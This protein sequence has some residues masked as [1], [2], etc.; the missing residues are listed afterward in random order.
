MTLAPADNGRIQAAIFFCERTMTYAN[1]SSYEIDPAD[2]VIHVLDGMAPLEKA[3]I[4]AELMAKVAALSAITNAIQRAKASAEV[5]ALLRRIQGDSEPVAE[6]AKEV[7]AALADVEARLEKH[8]PAIKRGYVSEEARDL[9]AQQTDLLM[10]KQDVDFEAQ[11]QAAKAARKPATANSARHYIAESDLLTQS[12]ALPASATD[13]KA[14]S[15]VWYYQGDVH[16]LKFTASVTIEGKKSAGADQAKAT[17]AGIVAAQKAGWKLTSVRAGR[18]GTVWTLKRDKE[19]LTRA[20]FESLTNPVFSRPDMPASAPGHENMVA[21]QKALATSFI[22][23]L[24]TLPEEQRRNRGTVVSKM[25]STAVGDWARFDEEKGGVLIQ[26]VGPDREHGVRIQER[27]FENLIHAMRVLAM[28][29]EP[30]APVT[31]NPNTGAERDPRDIA[32][33]PSGT[34]IAD[35][36]EPLQAA[37]DR[38]AISVVSKAKGR[39][40]FGSPVTVVSLSNGTVRRIAR[41]NATESMGLPGWH[42]T[43][44]DQNSYL[45]DTESDAIAVI[46]EQASKLPQAQGIGQAAPQSEQPKPNLSPWTHPGTGEVRIYLKHPLIATGDKV[47]LVRDSDGSIGATMSMLGGPSHLYQSY[48][49]TKRDIALSLA[50]KAGVD[51]QQP[52]DDLARSLG[53]VVA[54]DEK[55]DPA[56]EQAAP[57]SQPAAPGDYEIVTHITVKGKELRG[58]I[59][60]DLTREEAKA[61][62][63]Y[64]FRKDGGWFIREK[65]LAGAALPEAKPQ[66]QPEPETPEQI[67]EREQAARDA[68]AARAQAERASVAEK[69]RKTAQSAIEKAEAEAGRD[70]LTNTHRRASM[71]ASIVERAEKSR[72]IGVTMQNMADA[73]E[74]DAAPALAGVKDR[75]TVETLDAILAQAT[76]EADR[77]LSYHEKEQR[78]GRRAEESDLRH[79]RYPEINLGNDL[80]GIFQALQNKKPKGWRDLERRLMRESVGK[81]SP[82]L[83]DDLIAALESVKEDHRIG[84]YAPEQAKRIRRL[85]RAGINDE[86]DLRT[87]LRQYIPLRGARREMD[88]VK[89]LEMSLI[90]QK[91]GFDFFPTPKPTAQQMVSAANISKGDR[92]LEPSAGNGN[93]ADAARDAGADVD[94]VEISSALR[95]ILTAKGH[96]VVAHDFE[97]FEPDEKYDAVIMNPPFSNRKDAEHIMRAFDMLKS[98]GRL[99]AIA[100]E[101]VFFGSDAKAVAFREWIEHHAAEVEQLPEGTFMDK[102]LLATTSARGRMLVMHKR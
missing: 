69:L 7:D 14:G 25:R 96:K 18:M 61:I 64:T 73:I 95:D 10:R 16:A 50:E 101:G 27:S 44:K 53:A 42:D 79:I 78:K 20:G 36:D 52:F 56:T 4:G 40:E 51:M 91:V 82:E 86:S 89:K 94:V 45:G 19:F 5:A 34:L 54:G 46:V 35:P 8:M 71:A 28:L 13:S 92:V 38:G 47:W 68:E 77:N 29:P 60:K 93:L 49:N 6:P 88:P 1:I 76:Y 100:G 63:E 97:T 30:D 85:Q 24:D 80:Q 90:G 22:E 33:D 12:G 98:G 84:W 32:S 21:Q 11:W 67:A 58:I 59:R 62:D 70:R 74:T 75:A 99:V 37:P 102:T 81:V 65:H 66:P 2:E 87:A 3:K 57:E 83:L 72:A 31:A 15:A 9:L 39:D 23:W 43:E 17:L 26:H 41:L 48:G 55:K